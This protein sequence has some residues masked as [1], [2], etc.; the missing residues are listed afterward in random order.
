MFKTS[1]SGHCSLECTGQFVRCLDQI[2]RTEAKCQEAFLV[3][4]TEKAGQVSAM[5]VVAGRVFAAQVLR[6]LTYDA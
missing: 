2:T 1:G 6:A 3:L 4:A 5:D